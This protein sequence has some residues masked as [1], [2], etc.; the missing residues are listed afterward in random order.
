MAKKNSSILWTVAQTGENGIGKDG[1][2]QAQKNVGL[3]TLYSGHHS[4]N[5]YYVK[6]LRQ[7]TTTKNIVA[8]QA[9]TASTYSSSSDAPIS[10]KGVADAFT[11]LLTGL[12]MTEKSCSAS[13][14]IDKISESDGK[15]SVSFQDIAISGNQVTVADAVAGKF[16]KV[17]ASGHLLVSN[18]D[19]SSWNEV[20]CDTTESGNQKTGTSRTLIYLKQSTSG[21]LYAR[22][23]DI[24]ITGGQV[25]VGGGSSANANKFVTVDSSGHLTLS[26]MK[27]SGWIT[28]RSYSVSASHTIDTLEQT[29][30]GQLTLTTKKIAING[31]QV[32]IT[33]AAANEF[34]CT[35]N[36]SELIHS[37][38]LFDNTAAHVYSLVN[39]DYLLIGHRDT[40]ALTDTWH[41]SQIKIQTNDPYTALGHDGKWNL[42]TTSYIHQSSSQFHPE[43]KIAK[44]GIER[45]SA[46][47]EPT[48]TFAFN[49]CVTGTQLGT[50]N[51]LG[52]P[53]VLGYLVPPFTSQECTGLTTVDNTGKVL[54]IT[55]VSNKEKLAWEY[56]SGPYILNMM[57]IDGG[58]Y[59]FPNLST[60]LTKLLNRLMELCNSTDPMGESNVPDSM[61]QTGDT[62]KTMVKGFAY[63]TV[64]D[65]STVEWFDLVRVEK[66]HRQYTSQSLVTTEEAYLLRLTFSCYSSI[67]V[68]HPSS[69]VAWTPYVVPKQYLITYTFESVSSDGSTASADYQYFTRVT[70]NSQCH[71]NYVHPTFKET[72]TMP[73][74]S[75][76]TSGNYGTDPRVVYL[77]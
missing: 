49:P 74:Y 11:G 29:A 41:T 9:Q 7:D 14:T 61:I 33:G 30:T 8:E 59:Q 50:G 77:L 63:T 57:W 70:D 67:D 18:Y 43:L 37:K 75:I 24:A 2:D 39:D 53:E 40:S 68:D 60:K 72:Y 16:V 66:D 71:F 15:I 64:N 3:D 55:K 17:D 65:D 5:G 34:V 47:D 22:F 21:Q 36:S 73:M 48:G 31:D 44:I 56:R 20:L 26:S 32:T 58:I 4:D 23:D 1:R 52:T 69:S 35:D 19:G 54:A 62:T 42:Y 45:V 12:K 6:Y 46:F 13:Q 27:D 38:V 25:T 51:Q 10:G 28:T 76:D